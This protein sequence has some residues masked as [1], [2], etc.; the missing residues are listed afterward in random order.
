MTP[1]CPCTTS[2]PCSSS[3]SSR[4]NGSSSRPP[5]PPTRPRPRLRP[6]RRPP[7]RR[8]RRRRRPVL[9]SCSAPSPPPPR[10]RSPPTSSNNERLQQQ[11]PPTPAVTVY[12]LLLLLQRLSGC[13]R[14]SNVG[15]LCLV[16]VLSLLPFPVLLFAPR[17]PVSLVSS[18]CLSLCCRAGSY[19]KKH[20]WSGSVGVVQTADV[21]LFLSGSGRSACLYWCSAVQ[22]SARPMLERQC[23]TV[24]SI[25]DFML[26]KKTDVLRATAAADDCCFALV[27][28]SGL[29]LH[30]EAANAALCSLW[31]EG[32]M[33]CAS[34]SPASSS[35]EWGRGRARVR[36]T[37]SSPPPRLRPA[38][39]GIARPQRCR[40]PRP[41]H[42]QP[43]VSP[44]TPLSRP[45]ASR[46]L[47]EPSSPRLSHPV[48]SAAQSGFG[49]VCCSFCCRCA[50][51]V[52]LSVRQRCRGA[53]ASGRGV[54]CVR[55]EPQ[56][57]GGARGDARLL[58]RQ[59]ACWRR[60]RL[61]LWLSRLP[62]IG[63]LCWTSPVS[64]QA[65]GRAGAVARLRR[66]PELEEGDERPQVAAGGR[67]AGGL[68]LL[69]PD[70][71]HDAEPGGGQRGQGAAPGCSSLHSLCAEHSIRVSVPSRPSAAPVSS[72]CSACSARRLASSPASPRPPPRRRRPLLP[73]L[74]S[75]SW[76]PSG[77]A[78]LLVSGSPFKIFYISKGAASALRTFSSS[79]RPT[80][81]PPP[82]PDS[83]SSSSSLP[84]PVLVPAQQP[85]AS[86]AHAQSAAAGGGHR[87]ARAGQG[88]Q[89]LPPLH[90]SSGAARA[91]PQ[92][93][94]QAADA[95]PAGGRA[96]HAQRLAR[97][98][99]SGHPP[100]ARAGAAAAAAAAAL[101]LPCQ[102]ALLHPSRLSR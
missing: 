52:F 96:A 5:P 3:S 77:L 67:S 65:G 69:H 97:G 74:R 45:A 13:G 40:R 85:R 71:Q 95:Q 79:S 102:R 87:A 70:C 80:P 88:D 4:H 84:L 19:F 32:L 61:L 66:Q 83:S 63:W 29:T 100:P 56:A 14:L 1:Y 35:S 30:V 9:L 11:Q 25:T 6:R 51:S 33:S 17:L 93:R 47:S 21:F 28:S 101:P 37:P 26:R 10:W 31:K 81:R 42:Q 20:D 73:C 98:A 78:S 44:S 18:A 15:C 68:L 12:A 36:P 55:Q 34:S 54:H 24:R 82:R 58:Q 99:D 94:R 89:H 7:R 92:R 86:E 72:S 43:R 53:D 41:P 39:A 27:S 76:L 38:I 2:A 23:L 62:G 22:A 91:L 90:R 46:R 48:C 57:R 49:R 50:A 16:S 75:L 60:G 64:R 59:Q 8:R